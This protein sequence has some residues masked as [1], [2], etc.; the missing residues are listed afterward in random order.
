MRKSK[1]DRFFDFCKQ[2][3]HLK[4]QCL[5]LI[6]YPDWYKGKIGSNTVRNAP[7][8]F[9]AN[10]QESPLDSIQDSTFPIEDNNPALYKDFLKFMHSHQSSTSY[11]HSPTSF[12]GILS[13]FNA[14][15]TSVPSDAHVWIIDTGASD[16]MTIFLEVFSTTY[17]LIKPLYIALPD[18][19]IKPV[20]TTCT[21]VLNSG[22][23][24]SNVFYIPDFKHNLLSVARLL[25]QHDLVA[26]F[27]HLLALFM[28]LILI[29]LKLLVLDME[30][31][32]NSYLI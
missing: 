7:S 20:H 22:I 31:Y 15:G 23:T 1:T 26:I 8:K 17:Q 27:N 3:R 9:A 32:I 5:K 24:L 18:G 4:D 28:I 2:K 12:A 19:S 11:F 29:S 21:V 25:D 13:V 14:S 6:G 16:H 30:D 10:V